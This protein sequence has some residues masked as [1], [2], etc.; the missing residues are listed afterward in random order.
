MGM[1]AVAVSMSDK[2]VAPLKEERKNESKPP[3][4]CFPIPPR[5]WGVVKR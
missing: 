5:Q 4:Q 1:P 2:D 3:L